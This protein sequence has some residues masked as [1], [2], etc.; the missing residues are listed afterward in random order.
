MKK[1][2]AVSL[3]SVLL[4]AG[5]LVLILGFIGWQFASSPASSEDRPVIYEVV[6]GMTFMGVAR[7]LEAQGVIKN[8]NAFSLYARLTGQRGKLK[9]GEYGFSTNMKPREVMAILAS[10]RSIAKP[11]TVSEGLNIFDI[12]RLY[13]SLGFGQAKEFMMLAFDPTFASYLVGEQVPSLEGYLY[14]ETYQITKFTSTRELITSMVQRF[15]AVWKDVEKQMPENVKM[16]R[17]EIITLS[18]IIEKETGIASERPLISSVFHNRFKKNMRLQTDPTIIYGMALDRR[19]MPTN[20]TRA[21]LRRPHPYNSYLNH[22]LPPGPISNP[23]KKAML[24]ALFPAKS[25]YL[26]FVSRNDGTHVFS[27][28]YQDHSAAVRKFQ[29]DPKARQGKSW[30]DASRQ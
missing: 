28:S 10:G 11:F 8:A 20:I 6:T 7:D 23:G 27:S 25:D 22:G 19:E 17:H 15:H 9:R 14:P 2:I 3:T 4:F 26:F 29:L 13:Q 1:A 12:A 18:S 21:D 5:A 30:R 16:S 24:A